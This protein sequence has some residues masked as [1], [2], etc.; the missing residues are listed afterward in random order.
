V[1]KRLKK[2]F[3]E[4]DKIRNSL[5]INLVYLIYSAIRI[6][7]LNGFSFTH[8]KEYRQKKESNVMVILGA[9]SSINEL[10]DQQMKELGEYDVAGLS[11]SCI[12]NIRQKF[13]F[14]ES[15]SFHEKSLMQEHA[16]KVFPAVLSAK[17]KGTIENIFWKNSENKIF[18]KYADMS[19]CSKQ[20]VCNVL[21]NSATIFNKIFI[22][23]FRLGLHKY[24]LIQ[25]RG[26][27]TSLIHLA[28]ILKYE[29][30][31]F[32][33]VDLNNGGYFFDHSDL[34]DKYNF[35]SPYEVLDSTEEKLHR[36]N[37]SKY[38]TPIIEYIKVMTNEMKDTSYYVSSKRTSLS[39]I[40]NQWN[41]KQ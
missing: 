13:F 22:W 32:V 26:S 36:T 31:I 28:A 29:K 35:G 6:L 27:V 40:F 4:N 15:A 21:T 14:Y 8:I 20:I 16:S 3:I 23:H 39:H 17:K 38:G 2:K 1:I 11:Y 5:S 34:Y 24:F 10:T 19:M 25:A 33:G 18:N 37:N 41:F 12:L 7:A 30:V 9:G